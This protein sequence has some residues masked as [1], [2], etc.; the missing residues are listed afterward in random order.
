MKIGG[1]VT[2]QKRKKTMLG[3]TFRIDG[4]K[5]YFTLRSFG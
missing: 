5:L 4:V 3:F 1:I 2:K